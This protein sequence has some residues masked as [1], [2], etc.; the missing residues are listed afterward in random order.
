MSPLVWDNQ[1]C[2]RVLLI[3]TN[4]WSSDSRWRI[5][6]LVYSMTL[7]LYDL[8]R[9]D[10]WTMHEIAGLHWRVPYSFIRNQDNCHKRGG[11]FE[12]PQW[13]DW[14]E[15]RTTSVPAHSQC[16]AA[17]VA[18]GGLSSQSR[19]NLA[20]LSQRQGLRLLITA[21]VMKCWQ[22]ISRDNSASVPGPP[23]L[24]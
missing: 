9:W 18:V 12:S 1:L 6:G 7:R 14:K 8:T 15:C 20:A 23:R 19:C 5:W 10:W 21:T 17:A 11:K 3:E 22:L 16:A 24:Y 2:F 4:L 13:A